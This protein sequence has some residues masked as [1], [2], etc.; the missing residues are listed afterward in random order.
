MLAHALSLLL[1]M[2]S[3]P[4]GQPQPY[5]PK[6]PQIRVTLESGKYFIIA[7]D[8][9]KSPKTALHIMKLV[10][11]KFYDGQKIHRVEDWVIQWGDPKSRQGVDVEG[12]GEGGSGKDIAFEESQ[13]EFVRGI[14]GLA[15]TGKKVGGDSQL[16]I[17]TKDAVR[18]NGNYAVLGKVTIGMDVVDAIKKGDTVKKMVLLESKA[19][20]PPPIS[21]RP[22]TPGTRP[23]RNGGSGAGSGPRPVPMNDTDSKGN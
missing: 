6:G 8:V 23:P 13:V 19:A 22:G 20:P 17:L 16:F 21:K 15:S 3:A 14:V 1:A 2:Q 9:Q 11:D 12:V 5:S 4:A 18:L 7:T 10:K